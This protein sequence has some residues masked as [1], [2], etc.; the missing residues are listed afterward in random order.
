MAAMRIFGGL[1]ILAFYAATGL[2]FHLIAYGS[3]DWS[4][5]FVYVA[6]AFWP[7]LLAWELIKVLAIVGVV[8]LA[9]VGLY[10]VVR[11]SMK[12]LGGR[13]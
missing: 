2:A 9:G 3:V 11:A 7:V 1:V 10:L 5:A 12:R 13:I 6:M 8:V 4:G